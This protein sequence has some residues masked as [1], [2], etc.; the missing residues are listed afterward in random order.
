[1]LALL[2]NRDSRVAAARA[3]ALG[4]SLDTRKYPT[5]L[6]NNV[7][8]FGRLLNYSVGVK[9]GNMICVTLGQRWVRWWNV[10]SRPKLC[11]RAHARPFA[12]RNHRWLVLSLTIG[13]L[14]LHVFKIDDGRAAFEQ[15][16]VLAGV[17]VA[18]AEIFEPKDFLPFYRHLLGRR[19]TRE[20]LE[21]IAQAIT[22]HYRDAGFLLSYA[23]VA[24]QPA[25]FGIARLQVVEG[26][27]SQAQ[28]AGD[29]GDRGVIKAY[30]DKVTAIRPLRSVRLQRYLLLINDLPG[31]HA[32]FKLR[33]L[34]DAGAYELTAFVN[35][36][37]HQVTLGIDNRG[38]ERLGPGRA[39]LSVNWYSLFR[40]HEHIGM[41]LRSSTDA[42]EL[43]N[44]AA[45]AAWPVGAEGQML[46]ASGSYTDAEPGGALQDTQTEITAARFMLGYEFSAI[47]RR[48]H[49][50]ALRGRLKLYDSTTDQAGARIREDNLRSLKLAGDYV[51]SGA[52]TA[53]RSFVQL[54]QGIDGLGAN[55]FT[56][57]GRSNADRDLAF[58]KAEMELTYV[59]ELTS[60][61]SALL[62]LMAQ[63]TDDV[64]PFSEYFTFGGRYVG[65]AYDPAELGGDRGAALKLELRY[66]TGLRAGPVSKVQFYAFY[67][68][69]AVWRRDRNRSWR[70]ESAAAA[71][72]GLRFR[73]MKSVTGYLEA[74]KPLTRPSDED[75]DDVRI[76]ALLE[77]QF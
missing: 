73:L 67:D 45:A 69:G 56:A 21:Q 32:H 4:G 44:V 35:R 74:A 16:F 70:R 24:A 5:T 76:F 34:A 47:R 7:V 15:P 1:M 36:R 68:T 8:I 40:R 6:K 42:E 37:K 49:S 41:W 57:P 58:T 14:G 19:V 65:R 43:R 33:P 48:G 20:Q 63:Y 38:S 61:T 53:V 2:I 60:T 3:Y 54:S 71:G 64:L 66:H 25:D 31:V 39:G 10:V 77:Y 28:L 29:A 46:L 75:G 50:L 55:K 52:R 26:Y 51:W 72:G 17:V 18:G 59:T 9:V 62:Q 22:Q 12:W 30:L 23:T 13:M 27:I 11:V